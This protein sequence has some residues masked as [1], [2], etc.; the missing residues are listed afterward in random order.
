MV[1]TRR[2]DVHPAL[3][4]NDHCH[5]ERPVAWL[6]AADMLTDRS[7]APDAKASDRAGG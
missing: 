5:S 1:E 2:T 3:L 6:A 7:G 4:G